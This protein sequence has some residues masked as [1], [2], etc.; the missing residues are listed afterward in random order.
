MKYSLKAKQPQAEQSCY[1]LSNFYITEEGLYES[2]DIFILLLRS[3]KLA[4][5]HIFS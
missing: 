2:V 3:L 1:I 5:P 4:T